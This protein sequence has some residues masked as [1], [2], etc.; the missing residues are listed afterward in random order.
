MVIGDNTVLKFYCIASSLYL[1]EKPPCFIKN[2]VVPFAVRETLVCFHLTVLQIPVSPSHSGA[3]LPS[4]F[5]SRRRRATHGC[6]G[7]FNAECSDT[8]S[9]SG[10]MGLSATVCLLP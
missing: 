3:L 4:L 5:T 7:D 9:G 1:K 2:Y 6:S 10:P 8:S